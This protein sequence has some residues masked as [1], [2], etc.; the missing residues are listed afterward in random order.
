MCSFVN[1]I[2]EIGRNLKRVVLIGHDRVI[3]VF[4]YFFLHY[5][6]PG[7]VS[8]G[9]YGDKSGCWSYQMAPCAHHVNSSKYEPC[10]SRPQGRAASCANK[11]TDNAALTW[12]TDKHQGTGYAFAGDR[13]ECPPHRSGHADCK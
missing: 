11:C 4:K 12:E 9:N 10:D 2:F 13:P 6:S 7:I 8:G 1:G 5:K 3:K